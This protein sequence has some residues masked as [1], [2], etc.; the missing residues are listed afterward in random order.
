MI[1][2]L[3]ALAVAAQTPTERLIEAMQTHSRCLADTA[4]RLAKQSYESAST[5]ARATLSDCQSEHDALQEIWPRTPELWAAMD[6]KDFNR[7]VA[8]IVELR[9]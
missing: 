5:L 8:L 2:I 9:R 4:D 3:L 7:T 1:T 6:E